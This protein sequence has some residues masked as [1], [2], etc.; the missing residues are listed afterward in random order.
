MIIQLTQFHRVERRTTHRKAACKNC[1]GDPW[2]G[3]T[4]F[5]KG[6]ERLVISSGFGPGTRNLSLCDGCAEIEAKRLEDLARAIRQEIQEAR[7][8]R[9]G[10][11]P[12]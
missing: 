2:S 7:S 5:E 9:A 3:R 1:M 6:E 8:L 12:F 4:R 10:E 11:C